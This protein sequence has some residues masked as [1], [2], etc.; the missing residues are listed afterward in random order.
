LSRIL[1][2]IFSYKFAV[3]ISRFVKSGFVSTSRF[4]VTKN[5]KMCSRKKCNKEMLKMFLN[6]AKDFKTPAEASRLPGE[7]LALQNVN[8]FELHSFLR[9]ILAFLDPDPLT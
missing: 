2:I 3:A 6:S 9:A 4:V 5:F 7:H 1:Y 8:F